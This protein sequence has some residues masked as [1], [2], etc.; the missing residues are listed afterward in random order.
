MHD[1]SDKCAKNRGNV[2]NDA[3]IT[4]NRTWTHRFVFSIMVF[5]NIRIGCG[6]VSLFID[7]Y[8]LQLVPVYDLKTKRIG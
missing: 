1:F 5:K 6:K 3:N 2:T 7:K 8:G 4:P